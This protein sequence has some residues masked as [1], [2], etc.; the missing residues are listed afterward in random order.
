[1]TAT[2]IIK[3]MFLAALITSCGE[4]TQTEEWYMSHPEEL[5]KEVEKCK[6]KS[7]K[8]IFEDRHCKVIEDA[9][10]KAWREHQKNAPL[11]TFN[12]KDF[13]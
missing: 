1:M 11:P 8:E 9:R 12:V 5:K 13:E 2:P 3:I 10:N 4:K 7:P 6:L